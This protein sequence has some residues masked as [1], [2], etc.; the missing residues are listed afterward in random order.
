[1]NDT[2]QAAPTTNR[3][4]SSSVRGDG[5]EY[6]LVAPHLLPQAVDPERMLTMARQ[7]LDNLP[8]DPIASAAQK[9]TVAFMFL[10]VGDL[11]VAHQLLIESIDQQGSLNDRGG[12][13]RSELRLVQTLQLMGRP[14]EAA[15]LAERV[16]D[17]TSGFEHAEL[18]HFALHHWGKALVQCGQNSKAEI[19]LRKALQIRTD[20]GNH[21]LMDSTHQAMALL[22]SHS[23]TQ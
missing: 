15:K 14:A 7:L 13:H 18:H 8:D 1:M 4:H 22:A 2:P 12:L 19:A 6:V 21:E 3:S 17:R 16:V 5:T 11:L 9:S 10:C 23:R 20:L